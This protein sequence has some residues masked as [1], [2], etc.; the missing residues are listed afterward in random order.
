[1]ARRGSCQDHTVRGWL[2]V[3][4]LCQESHLASLDVGSQE[5]GSLS[6]LAAQG[7]VSGSSS[8]AEPRAFVP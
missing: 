3:K 7:R 4:P 5:E 2:E 8:T 6:E 1:M